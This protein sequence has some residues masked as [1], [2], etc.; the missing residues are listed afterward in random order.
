[1]YDLATTAPYGN[2]EQAFDLAKVADACGASYV[3]RTTAY[4]ARESIKL[5]EKA[6]LNKG[7]SMVEGISECPTYY[8]RKNKK[9]SAVQIMNWM[10]THSVDVRKAASMTEE[11]L[12]GKIVIGEFKN[13][14]QPE[15]CEIYM[16][17]AEKV[18]RGQDA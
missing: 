11:E 6:L 7:F 4:H 15:Y 8:G 14:P 10:K 18:R 9:G 5:F 3:A 12:S 17:M 1:M 16:E 2:M 13:R